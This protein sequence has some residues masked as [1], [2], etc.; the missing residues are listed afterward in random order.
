MGWI[1]RMQDA[2]RQAASRG[3][4]Q[5]MRQLLDSFPDDDAWRSFGNPLINLDL[6]LM[7]AACNSQPDAVSMLLASGADADCGHLG[8][9]RTPLFILA[10][11][12]LFMIGSPIPP[13]ERRKRQRATVQVLLEAGADASTTDELNRTAAG[14]ALKG[15]RPVL[16]ML[17]RA[18]ADAARAREILQEPWTDDPWQP[19]NL[20]GNLAWHLFE[21]I[22]QAGA[23][24][25]ENITPF[26]AYARRHRR[27]LVGVV[28]KLGSKRK[29]TK[30]PDD[31]AGH[32]VD[33]YCPRGGW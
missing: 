26:E 6:A 28:S 12:P 22:E 5:E 20:P 25:N 29:A 24:S 14:V 21:K 33:F 23:E 15:N 17:M 3:D 11:R 16:L 18:G 8:P 2:L 30:L 19:G 7:N 10:S 31:V 32:V 13:P 1:R 4:L 9:S 27:L